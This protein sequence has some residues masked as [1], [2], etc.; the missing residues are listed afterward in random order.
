MPAT[1]SSVELIFDRELT[2]QIRGIWEGF[3]VEHIQYQHRPEQALP[4][5]TLAIRDLSGGARNSFNAL[6]KKL[7]QF[8]V[9]F[10]SAGMFLKPRGLNYPDDSI[11]LFL[12]PKP[13]EALLEAHRIATKELHGWNQGKWDHYGPEQWVPHCTLAEHL[14]KHDV[15]KVLEICGNKLDWPITGWIT[16]IRLVNFGM[17]ELEEV[18]SLALARPSS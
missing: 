3:A 2:E 18:D 16:G 12:S 8:R 5:I 11:V 14:E 15:Q 6:A 4:H 1:A 13:T 17:G 9:S 7:M 10:G